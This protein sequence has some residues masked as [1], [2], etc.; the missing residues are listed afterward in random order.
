MNQ[1][2]F[3]QQLGVSALGSRVRRLFE[4]LNVSVSDTYRSEIGFEQRWFALTRFLETH[5]NASVQQAA[6]AL[7][8]SHV[9]VTQAAKAMEARGLLKRC[10]SDH[11]ARVALLSLTAEGQRVA[12]AVELISNRVD[13][14]AMELL[15][16]A[17]PGFLENL[18]NLEN[19]L[20]ET[21]FKDRLSAVSNAR[22]EDTFYA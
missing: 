11:D 1:T 22:P 9:A 7:G 20:R 14:A 17:A 16:E 5:D 3:L 21:P 10:R 8:T 18:T 6:D 2:D 15:D 4:T 13:Q 19:A 12:L